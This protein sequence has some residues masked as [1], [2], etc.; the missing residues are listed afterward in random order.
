MYILQG[1]TFISNSSTVVKLCTPQTPCRWRLHQR[2]SYRRGMHADADAELCI[3]LLVIRHSR[4]V[5]PF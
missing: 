5:L 4:L 2:A 1:D 3:L